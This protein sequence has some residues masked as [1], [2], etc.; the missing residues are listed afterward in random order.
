MGVLSR[1]MGPDSGLRR[2]KFGDYY[3]ATAV[4]QVPLCVAA[5]SGTIK[6]FKVGQLAAP[7]G[8]ST[9]VTLKSQPN[10]NATVR[11]ALGTACTI[12]AAAGAG[13]SVDAAGKI[14]NATSGVT[15]PVFSTTAANI[16]VSAGDMVYADVTTAPSVS[17]GMMLLE[18]E[19]E[20][21]R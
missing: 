5:Q 6:N 17:A 15:A 13:Q 2:Q 16:R 18:V 1:S 4:A 9:V 3:S 8:G 19:I 12:T 11:T 14:A 21:D 7:G 20:W 10:L